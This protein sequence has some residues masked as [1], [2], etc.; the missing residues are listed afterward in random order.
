MLHRATGG[1]LQLLCDDAEDIKEEHV[2]KIVEQLLAGVHELHQLD[3]VHL[4]IKVGSHD[5]PSNSVSFF[6]DLA[7]GEPFFV[8]L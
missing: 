7:D 5:F 8:V 2:R 1:E 4:D 3:I 6:K